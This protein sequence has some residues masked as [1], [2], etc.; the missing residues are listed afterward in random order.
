MR[1]IL[2]WMTLGWASGTFGLLRIAAGLPR[3][4]RGRR[5]QRACEFTL[6]TLCLS[7]V[8]LARLL[9]AC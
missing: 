2:L 3:S 9:R 4:A 6:F 5:V 8:L 7:A 1:H